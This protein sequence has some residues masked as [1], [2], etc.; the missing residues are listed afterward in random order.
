ME[1]GL[2]VQRSPKLLRCY[3][4]ETRLGAIRHQPA[5]GRGA[6]QSFCIQ[7][8]G[9]AASF[10]HLQ[11]GNGENVERICGGIPIAAA[12]DWLSLEAFA[13]RAAGYPGSPLYLCSCPSQDS[14]SVPEECL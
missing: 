5:D 9:D 6:R 11:E 3:G 7:Q 8:R 13:S 1:R 12:R 14:F 2:A 10:A 4:V